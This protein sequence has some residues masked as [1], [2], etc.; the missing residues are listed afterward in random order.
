MENPFC[1]I[2]LFVQYCGINFVRFTFIAQYHQ[3]SITCSAVYMYSLAVCRWKFPQCTHIGLYQPQTISFT[4]IDGYLSYHTLLRSG[5]CQS[6]SG[7]KSPVSYKLGLLR[8]LMVS[9]LTQKSLE[10][11]LCSQKFDRILTST[12][13]MLPSETQKFSERLYYYC[14]VVLRQTETMSTY[15]DQGI[16][17]TQY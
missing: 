10:S 16:S 17:L 3:C 7:Y 8:L 9:C 15:T 1:C 13:G 2:I 6:C 5:I 12:Q 11:V 4:G 14:I